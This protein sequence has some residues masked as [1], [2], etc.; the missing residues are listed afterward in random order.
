MSA[1]ENF[2]NKFKQFKP[3]T[4]S[5]KN[6]TS[7]YL[8][9]LFVTLWG[10]MQFVTLPKEQFPD[11]VIPTIYVQTIYVGNSPKDIENLVTKPIE[12]QIKGITGAKINKVTSTSQQD[13]SAIT[14]EFSTDV[15]TDIAL[16]KV[17][18]AIDK[19][20]K[21]LPTDLTQE[22]TALE[23]SFSDQPIMYVNVYGDYD[24]V[25]LKKYADDLKDQLEE[26]PQITRVDLVGAPER[27]FQIN[28][29]NYRMQAANVTFDDI[30]RAVQYENL[31]V[32]GGLL[33][34]GN[35]KRNLQ[36]KGQ[37]KTSEDISQILVRNTSGAPVYL[38]DIA[39]IKDTTK[40][41]ESYA[42]LNGKNVITLNI[43]KRAGENLIETSDNVKQAVNELKAKEFPK[44]LGVVVTGDQS[45]Q[46]KTSF[47]DLVNSIVIGFV[48]VLIILMFFMGVTNAFFV[49]LSVP[50]SMFVAFIF[51]P[52][53]D[54]I[55]GT[56][57]TL[58]F[59]VL[60][61]LLFGL[62]IIVDDAIVVIENTHRIFTESKGKID[63][64]TSAKMAAGEVFIP[65][66]A[67]TLT[68]LAPFVPLLFWPGIIGKFMI[69]LPTMLIFTL[70]ASLI[71]AF[72]MNPVF[73]VD[74]MNHPE[75]EE[76]EKKTAIFKKPV[77]WALIVVGIILDLVGINMNSAVQ[78]ITT[79]TDIV[80]PG[81]SA[82]FFGNLLIFFALLILLNRFVLDGLIH[83]FQNKVLPWIM[84]H[85]EN[86]L[87]W[88]LT[89]WRPV[90]LLLGTIALLIFTFIFFGA[91][92]VPVVFF[93]QGDPNYIYVYLK[94]PV[95]T[96]VE[97]TDSLTRVLEEKVNKVLG[98]ENG[99]TNPAVE[100]IIANVA[101]G[102]N[103]PTSGDRSTRSELGRIQISFVEFEKR[104]GVSTKKYLDDIRSSL[105]GIPGAQ[106]SVDQ[107]K[108]G[109]PTDPPINVEVV[110]DDFNDLTKTA[111]TLKNYLD[112]INIPGVEELKMDVDLTNPEITLTVD[113]ERA[114]AAGVSSGQIGDALR[115]ALFGKEASKIKEGEDEYKIQIRNNE[116]QRNDLTALLNMDIM[117]R[118]MASGGAIKR[119]PISSVVKFD[120]TSTLGSV[121]RKNEK[122]TIS[123]I[124][125]VLT[126]Y[127]PTA[128]NA[129][130]AKAID[131]FKKKPDDVMLRQT[132]EGAQQAETAAFLGKA[133]LIALGSILVILVLQFNSVSKP[134]II[135]TEIIFSV[136]GVLLGFA[137]TGMEVSILM[138]GMGIVGLAG[139]VVK[140]GILVIEFADELRGRGLKT[141][142][143]VI[144][145]GKTRII[146]VLL[147]ALAAIL[148]L[149]PLAIGFNINFVTM[150]SELNPHIYFGGDNNVFW[151]PLSWTI[152]F[153]LAFAFF[154]TLVIVPS[155][156]LIGERLKRPMRRM[157]GGKW[158][159]FSFLLFPGLGFGNA[160][161]G[162][163]MLLTL[164]LVLGF[165]IL[166]IIT[167]IKH[168]SEVTRRK[169]KLI[170]DKNSSQ[171]WNESWF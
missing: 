52:A 17:K 114:L 67:G 5:I 151:K 169:R 136:I 78:G 165:P 129:D 135:L 40:E 87:R 28:V 84:S 110:S 160:L 50:L 92:K 43:I 134:I 25:R 154:M 82:L 118:D 44:D 109:P 101:V 60:F 116:Q 167:W 145:A 96:S 2:T 125:N 137:I 22:P 29:D 41:R 54:L 143:A 33:N 80:K 3:T 132:G 4:W 150:F 141:R 66:L 158:I 9:M 65:V 170:N 47:N 76:K 142:E 77:F 147:T 122:R 14:V 58:N 57:V 100:S 71:V 32:S 10:V 6:K 149:I 139:I 13:Y 120:L 166:M 55:V 81:G 38:K 74:F 102:A 24:L 75:G 31:D 19:S 163:N 162:G 107:E 171:A 121:K 39:T 113:R 98:T 152:I 124:S 46:T 117:F 12:K 73:A 86:L 103:D 51:L 48:L 70:T 156:Y 157:F 21:D 30:S 123:L 8:I 119:V 53:A 35:M 112:S 105:K 37:L 42:R 61:A 90:K 104:N 99:K 94:L 72:I 11:I 111:V 27:E 159:S 133:L 85:Y 88:A 56:H 164:L 140:N 26:L 34:V 62:G 20:K 45:K 63:A 64:P 83:R 16:Q 138:T 97:Y 108:G 153:G 18:D 146:P 49:A 115:T 130:I 148:A 95:G 91:R 23:V 69:Y 7:I 36:L 106:I 126:G 93:P 131:E 15:K 161:A 1:L 59:I 68:T 89:G 79:G 127:T 168:K 128:V 155:M 144:Q